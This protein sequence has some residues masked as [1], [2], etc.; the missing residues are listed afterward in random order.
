MLLTGPRETTWHA[1]VQG[2]FD[3]LRVYFPQALISECYAAA[4]GRPSSSSISLFE[5]DPVEDPALQ[6]LGQAF[7]ALPAYDRIAGPC[8]AD[9]LGLAYACRLVSLYC[10]RS[11]R[12][13]SF[14]G[15]SAVK[16]QLRRVLEY[17]EE[18]LGRPIYLGE[19]SEI[20]GLSRVHFAVQFK[21]AV[22]L[23]PYAYIQHR[24]IKRAQELL[25][26]PNATIVG[27]ALD[28]GFSSQGHFT[29]VFRK[30]VGVP[31]GRWLSEISGS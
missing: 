3:H 27:V 4:L 11:A 29:E 2:P 28:L 20:V 23:R 19:L 25:Q 1:L 9:S 12:Q 6:H 22:G 24:R 16:P 26:R 18:H 15:A 5:T 17:I 31:P 10:T 14:G 8:F 13:E 7:R 21:A 30:I